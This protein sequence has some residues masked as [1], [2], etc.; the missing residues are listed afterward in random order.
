MLCY[1]ETDY[2]IAG[3]P[4]SFGMMKGKHTRDLF[5]ILF[6]I[7]THQVL[8]LNNKLRIISQSHLF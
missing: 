8:G 7:I 1:I 6:K 4:M 5:L 3:P 2:M